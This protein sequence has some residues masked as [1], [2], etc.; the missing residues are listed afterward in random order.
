M[1]S[2]I[3]VVLTQPVFHT[4]IQDKAMKYIISIEVDDN[5]PTTLTVKKWSGLMDGKRKRRRME[6]G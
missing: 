5:A 4:T 3:V 6:S 2:K 1:S